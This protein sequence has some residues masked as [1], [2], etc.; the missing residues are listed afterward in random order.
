MPEGGASISGL[1]YT[2]DIV[3]SNVL[4]VA[5]AVKEPANN[6]AREVHK[7]ARPLCLMDPTLHT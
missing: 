7:T 2:K 6:G 4:S 3:L 5:V 1:G